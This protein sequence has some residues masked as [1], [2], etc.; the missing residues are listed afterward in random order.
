MWMTWQIHLTIL[1]RN[2]GT[3]GY[4]PFTQPSEGQGKGNKSVSLL[5]IHSFLNLMEGL[6]L[7]RGSAVWGRKEGQKPCLR[8]KL[9][10]N[11]LAWLSHQICMEGN[12]A[13]QSLLLS[14]YESKCLT[15]W[16]RFPKFPL[17]WESKTSIVT[18]YINKKNQ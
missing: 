12:F 4:I 3:L 18:S 15:P 6:H 2:A 13:K 9:R 5:L 11:K 17:L 8:L 10:M 16:R 7:I 1:R 14:I